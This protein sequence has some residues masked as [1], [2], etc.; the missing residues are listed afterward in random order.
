MATPS[1]KCPFCDGTGLYRRR[2]LIAAWQGEYTTCAPCA[3]TGGIVWEK[4][5]DSPYRFGR[6]NYIKEFTR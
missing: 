2:G 1:K 4:L 5:D 6:P 3:G